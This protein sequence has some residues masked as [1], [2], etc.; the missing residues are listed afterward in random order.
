MRWVEI[1]HL[2]AA[3]PAARV[4]AALAKS[5]KAAAL[6]LPDQEVC[7]VE[8]ESAF[9]PVEQG[10]RAALPELII[11]VYHRLAMYWNPPDAPPR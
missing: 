8:L 5:V 1:R 7:P 9:L 6:A 10:R 2:P 11:V 3:E 4:P